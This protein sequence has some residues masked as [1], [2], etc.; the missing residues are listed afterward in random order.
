MG[1]LINPGNRIAYEGNFSDG[2]PHG[3][4]II[5]D[6]EGLRHT[7]KWIMGIDS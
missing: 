6:K 2:L 4:G 3:E 1:R 5:V 7:S